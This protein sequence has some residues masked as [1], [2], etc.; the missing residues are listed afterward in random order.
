MKDGDIMSKWTTRE[1]PDLSNKVAIITGATSGI[2][3]ET[4][5]EI[6]KKNAITVLAVRNVEKGER[7]KN[8]FLKEVPNADIRVIKLDVAD[9]ESVHQFVNN[10]KKEFQSLN[11]LINNA[12]VM[13]PPYSKT[14][15]GFDIQMGTNH[16][17][18]FALTGLLFPILKKTKDSV[19]V[20]VS[21]MAHRAGNI[22]FDD[23][24]WEKRNYIRARAYGDSKLANLYFTYELDRRIKEQNLDIKVTAAHP[25]WTATELQRH[26]GSLDFLN[27]LFGQKPWKGA[28]PTL[29]ACFDKDL[30]SGEYFGPRGFSEMGGYPKRVKSNGLSNKQDLAKKL[31]ALSEELTNVT[32]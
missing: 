31:F 12:G 16:F 24:H 28:L 15:D 8:E 32:Y 21:S 14:K 4:A 19:I 7:V 27:F 25:G 22:D 13:M 11:Y 23:I 9:L 6:A 10:F 1:I 2:G 29:R 3:K 30:H 17:G 18:H 20:N 26:T 5:R